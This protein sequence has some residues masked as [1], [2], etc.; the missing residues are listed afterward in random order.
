MSRVT[1]QLLTC[2]RCGAQKFVKALDPKSLDGGFTRVEQ[3]EAADGWDVASGL[4][5]LLCPKCNSEWNGIMSSFMPTATK[6]EG[7]PT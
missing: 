5:K 6:E 3:F 1:G 2:D 7:E 4:Y